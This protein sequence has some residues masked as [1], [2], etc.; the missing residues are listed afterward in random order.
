MADA[1]ALDRALLPLLSPGPVVLDGY[2][3]TMAQ[4]VMLPGG[5][6]VVVLELDWHTARA[7]A[8]AAAAAS[9]KIDWD[10]DRRHAEQSFGL[11]QVKRHAELVV[12]VAGKTPGEIAFEILSCEYLGPPPRWV[13]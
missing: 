6:S 8:N 4:M 10:P 9:G 13:R 11:E 5:F 1:E 3:R 7:R 12:Q 2:P